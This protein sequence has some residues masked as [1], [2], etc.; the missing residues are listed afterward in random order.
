MKIFVFIAVLGAPC[1][2]AFNHNFRQPV[3]NYAPC[4][5]I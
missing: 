4:Q 3:S 2:P 5:P 1:V